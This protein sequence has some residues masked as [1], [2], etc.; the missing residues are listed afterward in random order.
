MHTHIETLTLRMLVPK[1][2]APTIFLTILALPA[3]IY[4]NQ[5][6]VHHGI[7]GGVAFPDAINA[8]SMTLETVFAVGGASTPIPGR[9]RVVEN[10]GICGTCILSRGC[11]VKF[12]RNYPRCLSG[13]WIWRLEPKGKHWVGAGPPGSTFSCPID[14]SIGSHEPTSLITWVNEELA[15]P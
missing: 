2:L 7:V 8:T 6:P 9:L 10:S 14:T 4:A 12:C 13:F 5:I 11:V 1:M 3:L 15:Q